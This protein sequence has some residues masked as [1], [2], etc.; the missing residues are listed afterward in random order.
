ML[1]G[2]QYNFSNTPS[3]RALPK[4]PIERSGPTA[5]R[6]GALQRERRPNK[7]DTG[8]WVSIRSNRPALP[9][10]FR[11]GL[12]PIG[13]RRLV[14][15][16]KLADAYGKDVLGRTAGEDI[17]DSPS[18]ARTKLLSFIAC[19]PAALFTIANK[20]RNAGAMPSRPSAMMTANPG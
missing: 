17:A 12:W 4:K 16:R 2:R 3:R 9:F 6:K 8:A 20:P 13:S 18:R 15:G 10:S 19:P 5:H 11:I 7:Q 14:D 1:S